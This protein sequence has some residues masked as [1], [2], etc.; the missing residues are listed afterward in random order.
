MQKKSIF[1]KIITRSAPLKPS[2]GKNRNSFFPNPI[3]IENYIFFVLFFYLDRSVILAT[4]MYRGE[5]LDS[6]EYTC[7]F[8][9]QNLDSINIFFYYYTWK[10][11]E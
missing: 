2:I 5:L 9:L 6:H 11:D 8:Q 7:E 3:F 4:L 10:V 1:F